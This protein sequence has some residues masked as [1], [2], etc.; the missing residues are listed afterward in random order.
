MSEIDPKQAAHRLGSSIN[1]IMLACGY[2]RLLLESGNVEE[3]RTEFLKVLDDVQ[4]C[5]KQATEFL[6][7]LVN[8]LNQG[9]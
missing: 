7:Q 2:A 3:N 5:S 4:K 8:H 6:D 1:A 9:G